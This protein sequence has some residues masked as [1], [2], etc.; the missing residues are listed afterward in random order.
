MRIWRN[1]REMKSQLVS[2]EDF[3]FLTLK[4]VGEAQGKTVY[5]VSRGVGLEIWK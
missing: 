2:W 3:T 5:F 1:R 4:I